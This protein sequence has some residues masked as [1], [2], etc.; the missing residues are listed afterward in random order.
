MLGL[1]AGKGNRASGHGKK[2][3]EQAHGKLM[4]CVDP[5]RRETN[6]KD[7]HK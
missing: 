1:F 2:R 4:D 6:I 7:S 3:N 5:F